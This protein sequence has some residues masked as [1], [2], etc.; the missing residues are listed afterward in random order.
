MIHLKDIRTVAMIAMIALTAGCGS[1]ATGTP[2]SVSRVEVSPATVELEIGGSAK[3]SAM[4]TSAAGAALDE[5]ITWSTENGAVASVDGSGL[6][7]AVGAGSTTVRATAAGVS[8]SAAVIVTAPFPTSLQLQK[9]ASGIGATDGVSPPGDSRFF[10][11]ALSGQI[12]AFQ[13]GG[14]FLFLDLSAKVKGGAQGLY[15]LAFHP[16]FATNRQFF[17]AYVQPDYTV[18]VERYSVDSSGAADPNSG[19]ILLEIPHPAPFDHFG[20]WI[21]FDPAGKLLITSGDGG[22]SNAAKARDP[23]SLL[24]KI[25]RIDVDSGDPYGIPSDNPY[26]GNAGARPEIWA[27]GLRNPW[28][29]DVDPE[30]GDLYFGDVGEDDWEEINIVGTGPG[31]FDF[32]WDRMEG[33]HC[34]PPSANGCSTAGLTLP[35]LDYPLT[36][37]A[38]ASTSQHPSGCSVTGGKVY[39]G[40]A[41]PALD[42]HYFYADFC[43]GWVRSF[44]WD[45]TRISEQTEWFTGLSQVIGFGRDGN[46]ELYL[47]SLDGDIYQ[48]IP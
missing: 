12:W 23:S 8:G 36:G 14:Q 21:G 5:P 22:P 38:G 26:V 33:T 15:S 27:S 41:I 40:S 28:R 1:D 2:P 16:N 20:G 7:T 37:S 10:V 46:G 6:V 17:V 31:G 18:V 3:L 13:G 45:G 9:V 43:A 29:A 47:L 39:R 35:R 4:A 25:L 19:K 44:R 30:S 32:G 42:G 24:G 11:A 48:I 34:Y